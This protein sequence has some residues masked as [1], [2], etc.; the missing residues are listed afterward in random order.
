MR[1][2]NCCCGWCLFPLL[3]S[4][5]KPMPCSY[6]SSPY[7][8]QWQMMLKIYMNLQRTHLNDNRSGL[9][10]KFSSNWMLAGRLAIGPGSVRASNC[11][12]VN[13]NYVWFCRNCNGMILWCFMFKLGLLI[14][15][16]IFCYHCNVRLAYLA[17]WN[18][19]S[20]NNTS[21]IWKYFI[22][23]SSINSTDSSS[24]LKT[25]HTMPLSILFLTMVWFTWALMVIHSLGVIHGKADSVLPP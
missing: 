8:L 5:D 24:N 2:Y 14:Y 12:I 1:L 7:H 22:H 16:W 3:N 23:S 18:T 13:E 6:R 19:K 11:T 4:F 25:P 9:V 17:I 20:E 21:K 10:S 15:W